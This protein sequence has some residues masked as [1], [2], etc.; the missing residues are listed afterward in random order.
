V[1]LSSVAI[2]PG[3]STTMHSMLRRLIIIIERFDVEFQP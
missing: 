3:I 2:G 1:D